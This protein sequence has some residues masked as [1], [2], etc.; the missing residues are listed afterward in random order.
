MGRTGVVLRVALVGT[1][2]PTRCGIASFTASLAEAVRTARPEWPVR[3]VVSVDRPAGPVR[4]SEVVAELVGGSAGSRA[5]AAAVLERFDA[6]LVQHEFGI[7]GGEDGYELLALVEQL[8]VPMIVVLHT[9]LQ[10]PTERQR[11]ILEQ[12]GAIAARLVVQSRAARARLLEHYEVDAAKIRVIP[13][14]AR[15]NP[16]AQLRRREDGA[17]IVLSWGLLG[18]DKGYEF[19]IRALASLADLEH[20]PRYVIVGQTHPKVRAR[21]GEAYR[22]SLQ[23]LA[24]ELGLDERVELDDGYHDAR[25][26]Q[27]RL[28]ES[29]VVLL[30]YRSREQVVSGVLV[31]A[32]AAG[33]PVVATRFPHAEELVGEGSGLLVPHEDADAIATALRRLLTEPA[34]SAEAAAVARRQAASLAWESVGGRYARLLEEVTGIGLRAAPARVPTIPAPRFEHLLRLSDHVGVF[35]HAKLTVPRRECGYCTDDVARALVVLLREPERSPRL[36]RLVSVCFAFLQRA[37]LPDGRFHNRLS[38]DGRWLDLVGSDDAV[39][40]ALWASGVAAI[41]ATSADQREQAL[42]M[43][44]AGAG[45]RSRWPRANAFALLGGAELLSDMPGRAPVA[46]LEL[47]AAAAAG[48][49]TCSADPA[50]PWPEPRLAYA[51]AVLAEAR[52]AAG[53][54]LDDERLLKKGLALLDWLAETEWRGSHFSFAPVGGWALGERRPGFDQ[55]PI[56]AAAMVDACA[57]AFNATGEPHWALR[58]LRAAEWFLGANDLGVSLL[59]RE[60]GGCRDGLERDGVNANEGAESTLALISA[61]QQSHRLEEAVRSARRSRLASTVA[62]PMQWSA[63]P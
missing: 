47:V 13:H 1:Y 50:W 40:R 35:E 5:T 55:Q 19:G 42:M 30:P 22:E 63:A 14:G 2:P 15:S 24:H 49:G 9:V 17:P 36:E 52:I 29:A 11:Q 4:S 16:L 8:S 27:R 10:R 51:N 12:L 45:F 57:R 60:T 7:Y 25:S 53:V 6:V 54:V 38:A 46:A 59:D 37:Q 18:P 28:Q 32:I 62:A 44:E 26:L 43:F 3:V 48:L 34:R 31:E 39:G 21:E 56:E 61:L 23:A 41:S 20:A 58:A 33:K